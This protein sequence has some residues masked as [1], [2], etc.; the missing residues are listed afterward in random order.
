MRIAQITAACLIAFAVFAFDNAV[1]ADLK[2]T[3][4]LPAVIEQPEAPGELVM[5][6]VELHTESC[7]Q[8]RCTRRTRRH[9]PVRNVLKW[10][11]R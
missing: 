7:S 4:Y 2:S 8:A 10:M 11:A 1:S 6:E 9:Q 5:D 3:I